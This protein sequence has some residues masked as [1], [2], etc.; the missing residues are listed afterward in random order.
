VLQAQANSNEGYT[1]VIE[2]DFEKFFE[3]FCAQS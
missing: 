3:D 2:L 1:W